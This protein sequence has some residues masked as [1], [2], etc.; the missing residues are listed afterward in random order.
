MAA[1]RKQL[2]YQKANE[3]LFKAFHNVIAHCYHAARSSK[4]SIR[5]LDTTENIEELAY[6]Q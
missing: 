6:T 5:T 4:D 2:V 1:Q 3:M